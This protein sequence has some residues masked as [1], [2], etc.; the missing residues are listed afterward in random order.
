[1]ASR[2]YEFAG[3]MFEVEVIR[4]LDL[5]KAQSRLPGNLTSLGGLGVLALQ[6]KEVP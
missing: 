1:M 3:T 6:V 5:L 2:I 4:K